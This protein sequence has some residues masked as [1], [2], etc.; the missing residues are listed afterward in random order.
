MTTD[1]SGLFSHQQEEE[2][3]PALCCVGLSRRIWNNLQ[4]ELPV[5]IHRPVWS[6][7]PG[8][9]AGRWC[10]DGAPSRLSAGLP[11]LISWSAERAEVPHSVQGG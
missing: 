5:K 8:R 7:A 9:A 11:A 2:I 6:W 1:N 3:I 10:V 4:S